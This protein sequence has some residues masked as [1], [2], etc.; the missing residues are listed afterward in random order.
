MSDDVTSGNTPAAQTKVGGVVLP[1]SEDTFR[2]FIVG[3]LGKPQEIEGGQFGAFSIGTHEIE[4]TY[5][6]IHQR[7]T[8]QQG[9]NPV[10][11]ALR[12][13]YDDGTSIQLNSFDDFRN[14]NEPKPVI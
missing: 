12:I 14:F 8:Q 5:H 6:L 9:V 3:L 11:F 4:Q 7:V 1:C 2:D 13:V 10:G